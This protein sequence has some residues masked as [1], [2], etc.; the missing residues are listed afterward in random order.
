M[1]LREVEIDAVPPRRLAP[2]I[3]AERT[4]AFERLQAQAA[5]RFAG[6]T[7]WN[8]NSTATGG[9]VAE[10][11]QVLLAYTLGAG[12]D[13]RWVVIEANPPF[14]AITKRLHNRLHGSEGDHGQLGDAEHACYDEVMAENGER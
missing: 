7:V 4:E 1:A 5:E 2:I 14:F 6:R 9:G 10:L 11:L 12:V 8:V 13:T 3:G